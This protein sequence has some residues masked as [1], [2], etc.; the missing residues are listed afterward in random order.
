MWQE[1]A[2]L[3]VAILVVAYVGYKF[4]KAITSSQADNPCVGCPGCSLMNET[5]RQKECAL[6]EVNY[7]EKEKTE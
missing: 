4:Y 3:M 5:K 1:I 7:N 2:T 6:S